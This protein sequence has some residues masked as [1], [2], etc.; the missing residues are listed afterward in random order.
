MSCLNL[1]ICPPDVLCVGER[2]PT[3]NT[4]SAIKL[5]LFQSMRKWRQ[6]I[7]CGQRKIKKQKISGCW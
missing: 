3:H 6:T 1:C 2:A 7:L 5:T 4:N